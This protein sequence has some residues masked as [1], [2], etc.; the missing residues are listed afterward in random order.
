MDLPKIAFGLVGILL[1]GLGAVLFFPREP[2]IEIIP[3]DKAQ[4]GPASTIF[5]DIEGAVQNP[6]VYELATGSLLNDLLI[7]AGG[8]SASADRELA[9]KNLNLAQKLVDGSK[10]FIPSMNETIGQVAA[11]ASQATAKI[12]INTASLAQLD[13]LWGIGEK[14]AQTIIDSRP[15]QNVE[16][17]VSRKVV[18]QNVYERIKDEVAVY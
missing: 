12:N 1:I 17:L 11:T 9:A 6:G 4:G 5:V 18:P 13:T 3:F 15:Y 16:E 7:R 2:E 8:L 14:R 10:F